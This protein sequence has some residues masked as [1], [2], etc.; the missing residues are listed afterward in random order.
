MTTLDD[1]D[2]NDEEYA[3]GH[4]AYHAGLLPTD[5]TY[6]EGTDKNIAW[7]RGYDAAKAA[8][9]PV[10]TAAAAG[11]RQDAALNRA[12]KALE[13]AVLN[14]MDARREYFATDGEHMDDHELYEDMLEYIEE[15]IGVLYGYARTEEEDS[16]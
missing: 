15:L 8:G 5:T 4:D 9:P 10:P 11:L 7:S 1:D 16:D 6:R 12:A 13:E 14:Y 2:G 3:I